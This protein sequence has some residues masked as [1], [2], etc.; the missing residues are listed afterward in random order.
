M[1]S[2]KPVLLLGLTYCVRI[3]WSAAGE[4]VNSPVLIAPGVFCD[5]L[6][7]RCAGRHPGVLGR[8]LRASRR[9]PRPDSS[10]CPG[11]TN[12]LPLAT[13]NGLPVE[14]LNGTAEIWTFLT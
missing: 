4:P 10:L 11:T 13:V 5:G 14:S 7:P 12:A 2:S 1:A 8:Q 3:A 9:T 6:G